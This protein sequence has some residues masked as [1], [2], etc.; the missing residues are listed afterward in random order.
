MDQLLFNSLTEPI[1]GIRGEL[2]IIPIH[3]EG[4]ELLYFHDMLGYATDNF[5]LDRSVGPLMVHFTGRRT[6]NEILDV[7]HNQGSSDIGEPDLLRFIRLL[8][9]NRILRSVY[10]RKISEHFEEEF[11]S[12]DVRPPVTAGNSYPS[13]PKELRRQFDEAFSRSGANTQ[14]NG[15]VVKALYAPH[16]D[17]RV[18]MSSYVKAFG[19]LRSLRPKRVVLLAT[20][21]YAGLYNRRYLGKPFILT[22]KDFQTPLGIVKN[23]R[24]SIRELAMLTNA[25]IST[26]DRAHRIEHSIELHLIFLKYLWSHEFSL[27]PILVGSLDELLYMPDGDLGTKM[28]NLSDALNRMF[29]DD[30]ETLFLISGDLAHF[31]KKFGDK[32][33]ASTYFE[34]VHRFDKQLLRAAEKATPDAFFDVM[35]TNNDQYRIC[36]FPPL[37][38]FLNAIPGLEGRQTS[39]DLWD[40]RERESAVTFGSILYY[41][42]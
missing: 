38:T 28:V 25:G 35:K 20:S 10:F 4:R 34:E 42:A 19:P 24:E 26:S 1:P 39:Y 21:H 15:L 32:L 31:G 29:G 40:E 30:P 17:P 37:M 2:D 16:I 12:M 11:E 8:D 23:D 5:V 41:Q 6:V 27:V 7:I 36:G 18:G 33:P 3:H 9:Q 22:E 14:T 13:D